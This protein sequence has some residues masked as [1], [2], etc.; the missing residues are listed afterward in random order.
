MVTRSV[1]ATREHVR[2]TFA[3]ILERS[4][5]VRTSVL[6]DGFAVYEGMLHITMRGYEYTLQVIIGKELSIVVMK[7]TVNHSESSVD[8]VESFFRYN[9][10]ASKIG[11]LRKTA[12]IL[13]KKMDHREIHDVMST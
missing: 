2:D 6:G 8:L 10:P 1:K 7:C 5:D 11:K 3:R 13:L 4:P 9:C 12:L